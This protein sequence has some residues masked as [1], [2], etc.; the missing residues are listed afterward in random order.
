MNSRES[1]IIKSVNKKEGAEIGPEHEPEPIGT[2]DLS[3]EINDLRKATTARKHPYNVV[4]TLA[5][6]LAVDIAKGREWPDKLLASLGTALATAASAS[7]HDLGFHIELFDGPTGHMV[8]QEGRFAWGQV[9]SA[10]GTL[11]YFQV[12]EIP[13]DSSTGN[14]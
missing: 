4:R 1:G 12:A 8:A 3:D 9:T 10:S 5:T 2:I 11:L 13:E 6:K 7:S 14:N